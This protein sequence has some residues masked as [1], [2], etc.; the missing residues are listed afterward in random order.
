VL[1]NPSP[2]PRGVSRV[3]CSVYPLF[4][5]STLRADSFL[6]C[7]VEFGLYLPSLSLSLPLPPPPNA[8]SFCALTVLVCG[9]TPIYWGHRLASLVPACSAA[10][11]SPVPSPCLCLPRSIWWLA[12]RYSVCLLACFALP[13]L[14]SWLS[15]S[16][17]PCEYG[18]DRYWSLGRSNLACTPTASFFFSPIV[19]SNWIDQRAHDL[20]DLASNLP[21]VHE[22]EGPLQPVRDPFP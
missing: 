21:V 20:P 13:V 19:A 1:C 11:A 4:S 8:T 9:H 7:F 12:S 3:Q 22:S 15:H 17:L 6:S 14:D 5:F 10:P 2:W 16:F 18:Y